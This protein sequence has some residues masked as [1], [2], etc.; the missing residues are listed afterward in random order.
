MPYEEAIKIAEIRTRT[1]KGG[2]G[3][4]YTCRGITGT[5]S[6]LAAHFHRPTCVIRRWLDED[7][8]DPAD[9]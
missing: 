3:A 1:S 6:E 2:R 7:L 8:T 5:I 4:V 9:A